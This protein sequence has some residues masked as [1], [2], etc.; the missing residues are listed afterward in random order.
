MFCVSLASAFGILELEKA[1]KGQSCGWDMSDACRNM[2]SSYLKVG[3]TQTD[4]SLLLHAHSIFFS[5]PVA[6]GL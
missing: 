2:L 1:L 5:L 4:Q 6:V 3:Y